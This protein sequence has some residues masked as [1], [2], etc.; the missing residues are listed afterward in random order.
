M[1]LSRLT[2]KVVNK[3]RRHAFNGESKE[4]G[5]LEIAILALCDSWLRKD[6]EIRRLRKRMEELVHLYEQYIKELQGPKQ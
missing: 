1:D 4:I 6:S 5:D 2:R 3:L